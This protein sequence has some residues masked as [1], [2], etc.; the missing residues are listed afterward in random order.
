MMTII[1]I[2]IIPGDS[3]CSDWSPPRPGLPAQPALPPL[4]PPA[5]SASS[6]VLLLALAGLLHLPGLQ[7]EDAQM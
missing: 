7:Q 4:F 3:G 2:T 1:T 5:A 6:P